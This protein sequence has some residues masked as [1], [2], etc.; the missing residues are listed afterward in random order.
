MPAGTSITPVTPSNPLWTRHGRRRPSCPLQRPAHL[1]RGP[2]QTRA[3]LWLGRREIRQCQPDE[4]DH[5]AGFR[6]GRDPQRRP[7]QAYGRILA[8]EVGQPYGQSARGPSQ[9]HHPLARLTIGRLLSPPPRAGHDR[10]HGCVRRLQPKATLL[11]CLTAAQTER[12]RD[13]GPAHAG[14]AGSIDD[15]P[16]N[17]IQIRSQN[18]YAGQRPQQI[19]GRGRIL[20]QDLLDR[21]M[22][23]ATGRHCLI[24]RQQTVDRAD[25]GPTYPLTAG[26]WLWA[27]EDPPRRHRG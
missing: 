21:V 3:D 25:E 23:L 10:S 20:P 16:L 14:G 9:F 27:R 5:R 4:V 6:V 17:R 15:S 2:P 7:R 11:G 26:P 22:Q 18:G 24:V 12:R 8:S 13:I 19:L 1:C